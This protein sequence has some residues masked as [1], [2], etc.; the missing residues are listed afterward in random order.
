MMRIPGA[1]ERTEAQPHPCA[2][3]FLDPVFE[4]PYCPAYE[5][6]K[7]QELYSDR[8]KPHACRARGGPA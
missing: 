4:C 7:C 6:P 5:C 1:A 2:H 3:G 8:D